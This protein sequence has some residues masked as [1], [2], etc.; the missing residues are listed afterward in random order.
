MAGARLPVP[1][2]HGEG[3]V[4]VSQEARARLEHDRLVTARY[5][6]HYGHATEVYPRNPN[7]STGGIT[8]LTTPDGRFTALMPHPERVIRTAANSWHP[9]DWGEYGPWFEIFRNARRFVG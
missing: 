5:V 6:D 1:V 7:G 2:A 8:G 9:P 3:R 4:A